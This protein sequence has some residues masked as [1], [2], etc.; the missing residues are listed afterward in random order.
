[1]AG[2]M[3]TLWIYSTGSASNCTRSAPTV[4]RR[5]VI[6]YA[7]LVSSGMHDIWQKHE[8][9]AEILALLVVYSGLSRLHRSVD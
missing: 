5:K 3:F 2:R 6:H 8:H 4:K 9:E 7:Q 1:M